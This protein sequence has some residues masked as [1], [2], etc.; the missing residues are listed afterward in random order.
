MDEVVAIKGYIHSCIVVSA[1]CLCP[2]SCCPPS[3]LKFG[4]AA[5][6]PKNTVSN[7]VALI[8]FAV[9]KCARLQVA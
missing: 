6:F 2:N 3:V 4:R 5:G 8:G 9:E 7:F 1:N